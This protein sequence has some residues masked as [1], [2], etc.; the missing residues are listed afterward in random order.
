M[1]TW[2]YEAP[3]LPPGATLP[4]V[5]PRYAVD[6]PLIFLIPGTLPMRRRSPGEHRGQRRTVTGITVS[7]PRVLPLPSTLRQRCT[8]ATLSLRSA[9][10]HCLELQWDNGSAGES[11]DLRPTLP[12]VFRW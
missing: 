1:D 10:E 5:T 2:Q 9:A 11:C 6:G 12:L 8:L 4:I 3:F 7:G